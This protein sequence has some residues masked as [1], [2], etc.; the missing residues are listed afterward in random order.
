MEAN[1][2]EISTWK[3]PP[4]IG[5][6]CIYTTSTPIRLFDGSLI[7]SRLSPAA[8]TTN[9]S[10]CPPCAHLHSSSIWTQHLLHL[11]IYITVHLFACLASHCLIYYPVYGYTADAGVHDPIHFI[12]PRDCLEMNTNTD[13]TS[14]HSHSH[15]H[16]GLIISSWIN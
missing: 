6:K 12:T 13:L 9:A 10:A 15:S 11:H 8:T 14:S 2:R 16:I 4:A 7:A 1:A 3:H 5:V